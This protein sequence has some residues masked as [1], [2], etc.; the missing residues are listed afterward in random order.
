MG[1]APIDTIRSISGLEFL[2]RIKDEEVP[3]PT[4]HR[5]LAFRFHELEEGRAVFVG[6]ASADYMNPLGTFHGG[7]VSALLDSAM[8]C[9]AHSL[10]PAGTANTTV[11]FK[12]NFVRPLSLKEGLPFAEGRV[13]DPRQPLTTTEG[14]LKNETGKPTFVV[15]E[16]VQGRLSVAVS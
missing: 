5:A 7:F 9:S 2:R 13:L 16:F 11:E 14:F 4:I 15:A 6:E 10:C 3:Q 1:P 12:L 8:A